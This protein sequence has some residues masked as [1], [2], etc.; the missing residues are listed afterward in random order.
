MT[1]GKRGEKTVLGADSRG[2]SGL[3][4]GLVVL[5][6]KI[7]L[8]QSQCLSLITPAVDRHGA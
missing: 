5:K 6:E 4:F 2:E 3:C 7:V 1:Q 8:T